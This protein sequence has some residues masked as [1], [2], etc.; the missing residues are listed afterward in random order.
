MKNAKETSGGMGVETPVVAL[1]V[2]GVAVFPGLL[3]QTDLPAVPAEALKGTLIVVISLFGVVAGVVG[4]V[5][6]LRE[7]KLRVQDEP[8][9]QIRTVPPNFNPELAAERH[10]EHERR[11]RGLEEWRSAL[12][13][14]LERDKAEIIGAGEAR[15]ERIH[16]HIETDRQALDEKVENHRRELSEKIDGIP[17][18][19]IAILKNTRAI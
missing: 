14:K 15:A 17:G 9:V 6:S 7:R 4:F 18:Q 13:E 16:R 3:A 19:V 5:R 2:L 1:P 8:A 11:L 12:V 10:Q